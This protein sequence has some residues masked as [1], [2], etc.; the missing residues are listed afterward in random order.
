M[1]FAKTNFEHVHKSSRKLSKINKETIETVLNEIET[2][3]FEKIIEEIPILIIDNKFEFKDIPY[4]IKVCC[5]LNQIYEKFG[6]FYKDI[7]LKELKG[8]VELKPKNEDEEEK[9]NIRKRNIYRLVLESYLYGLLND[10]NIV[11]ELF[12]K[13]LSTNKEELLLSLNTLVSL[14]KLFGLILFGIKPKLIKQLIDC[15][16]KD[17]KNSCLY[18]DDFDLEHIKDKET[19]SKYETS[20]NNYYYKVILLNF[21]EKNKQLIDLEKRNIENLSKLDSNQDIQEKYAK[22]RSLYIKY[23]NLVKEYSNIVNNCK[24]PENINEKFMKLEDSRKA[25]ATKVEKLDKFDPFSDEYEYKFYKVYIDLKEEFPDLY[26]KVISKKE[27]NIASLSDEEEEAYFRKFD[28]IIGKILHCDSKDT[29]DECFIEM[30]TTCNFHK[31]RKMLTKKFLRGSSKT[32]FSLLKYYAR[33]TKH[34]SF[35]YKDIKDSIIESIIVD[36][37]SGFNS[38]KL[39]NMDERCKNIKFISEMVKF[40]LFPIESVMSLVISKLFEDFR[41]NTIELLCLLLDSCGRYL[42][43]HELAHLKFNAFLNSFKQ[44]ANQKIYYNTTLYNSVL[45]ALQVCKPNEHLLKHKVKVRSIEEE[46]IRYLIFTELDKNTIKKVAAIL[47]KMSWSNNDINISVKSENIKNNTNTIENKDS[48]MNESKINKTDQDL[49]HNKD[50]IS[51]INQQADQNNNINNKNTNEDI[52]HSSNDYYVFKY[53]YK[54]I[55]LGKDSQTD[56][57]CVLLIHLRDSHPELVSNTLITLLEEL[58]INLERV[59]SVD[60]QHKMHICNVLAKFYNYKL[61]S[62]DH[63]FFILYFI[64]M[65]FQDTRYGAMELRV[66]NEYDSD[67]DYSRI[68]MVTNILEISGEFLKKKDEQLNEFVHLLQMYI[69]TKKFLPTDIE[70]R[71]LNVLEFILG[72]NIKIYDDF[73]LALKDSFKFKGFY[74]ENNNENEKASLSIYEEEALN[75]K[76]AVTIT[77]KTENTENN[78]NIEEDEFDRK[79][80]SRKNREDKNQKLDDFDFDEEFKKIVNESLSKAKDTVINN[81][82]INLEEDL[83]KNKTKNKESTVKSGFKLLVKKPIK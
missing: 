70:N 49:K 82:I 54:L 25:A 68:L 17:N 37:N 76:R 65:Y 58:R 74:D 61:I 28:N 73:Q 44:V 47:R 31:Y 53:I 22:Q 80:Y 77:N 33:F 20:F 71:V 11:K 36:F 55:N 6:Y 21:E 39:N 32:N 66:D 16:S 75:N 50:L 7:I 40:D 78:N 57:A 10:F 14:L 13:L 26:N 18:L 4:I 79:E 29:C 24:L 72:K 81:N 69:L 83:K 19:L 52:K 8:L 51:T 2:I 38:D 46:Y 48:N 45:N 12:K 1:D 42:Y 56:L 15:K 35:F 30:L 62:T 41:N 34:I 27:I 60:N 9:K 64:I 63:V 3:N 43:V 67:I 23:L 5:E 59:D